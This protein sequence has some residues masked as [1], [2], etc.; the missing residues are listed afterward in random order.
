M[1]ASVAGCVRNTVLARTKSLLPVFEAVIN[2]FQAIEEAGSRNGHSIHLRAIR[3]RTLDESRPVAIEAFSISDTGIGFTDAN[4]DSFNIVDSP[5]K[6]AH[7]GKGLGRFLWLKAFERVEI[8]SHYRYSAGLGLLNRR[9]AF[10]ASDEDQPCMVVPSELTALRQPSGLSGSALPTA[11]NAP[12]VSMRSRTAWWRI[13]C[14]CS[15]I[16]MSRPSRLRTRPS[17]SARLRQSMNSR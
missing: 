7:G 14:R 5:Y 4:Y 6:A 11:M 8:D 9:F 2:S 13:S 15:S 17:S 1:K 10:I 3:E 12:A 16:R